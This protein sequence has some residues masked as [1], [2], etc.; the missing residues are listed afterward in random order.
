M[1]I[2]FSHSL[3]S[4]Q[5]DRN[6]FSLVVLFLIGLLFLGWLVWFFFVPVIVYETGQIVQTS[7]DGVVVAQ[8]PLTAQERLQPGQAVQLYLDGANP[9]EAIAA[10]V[11]EVTQQPTGNQIQV[12][13]YADMDA[14]SVAALQDG[15]TGQARVA[16]EQLSPARLVIRSTGQGV[17]TP[18]VSFDAAP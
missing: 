13:I 5:T 15:L 8:F 14:P 6:R 3:R 17:D 11:V 1:S 4:L 2:A 12:L 7:S 10:T 18:P 9:P 16:V